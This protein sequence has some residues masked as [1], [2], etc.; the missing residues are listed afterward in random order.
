MSGQSWVGGI[1]STR[2]VIGMLN[3]WRRRMASAVLDF[4]ITAR[5]KRGAGDLLVIHDSTRVSGL[6][7]KVRKL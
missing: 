4:L 1:A 3:V 5:K 7:G 2:V 6:L